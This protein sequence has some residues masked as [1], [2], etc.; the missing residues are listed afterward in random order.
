MRIFGHRNKK[1]ILLLGSYGRSNA[2]DDAFLASI[3]KLFGGFNITINSADDGKLPREVR[4]RVATISTVDNRDFF[5][6]IKTFLSANYIVY[7]GG[8]LWVELY[9][10]K[11][12]RQSLYKMVLV[13]LLSKIFLKKIFYLGCGAAK[14]EGLSLALARLSASMADHVIARD[15]KTIKIL[16]IKNTKEFPD[17]AVNLFEKGNLGKITNK[18][19][20]TI[21][22]SMLYFFPD[23]QVNFRKVK[24]LLCKLIKSLPRDKFNVILIPMLISDRI[25]TDDLWASREIKKNTKCGNIK[26]FKSNDVGDLIK[27]FSRLDLLIGARLHSNILATLAGTPALGISYR[28][29]VKSFFVQ[30]SLEE[31]CLDMENIG[32]LGSKLKN[33]LENYDNVRNQFLEAREKLINKKYLYDE[34]VSKNFA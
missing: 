16:G 25:R 12:P 22:I 33:M 30:N 27:V 6:K 11:Y 17:L 13:N 31:Y 34:F 20:F 8:D 26:I 24:K 19:R 21:G 14:L 9:G 15:E 23:P 5:K 29:K 18:D 2:G 32:D 10:D 28:D 1:N 3:L 7:G 4:D